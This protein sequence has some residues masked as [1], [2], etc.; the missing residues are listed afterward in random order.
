MNY[1]IF[2][3]IDGTLLTENGTI[4]ISTIDTLTKLKNNG[5]L[6]FICSGR[7]K[8]E[9]PKYILNL[10]F[11][12]IVASAG[13]YVEF[14]SAELFHRPIENEYLLELIYFFQENKTDF[15]LETNEGSYFSKKSYK[16]FVS[17]MNKF[18]FS[19]EEAKNE[20]LAMFSI[21][22]N[23]KKIK[24][25]NKL[26]YF[27]SKY[28]VDE[29]N[30]LLGSNFTFLPGSI[31]WCKN[32]SGEVSEKGINKSTGINILLSHLSKTENDVIAIGDGFNDIEMIAMAK[33]GIA[34]GNSSDQLKEIADYTTDDVNQ[35]GIYNIFRKLLL[36]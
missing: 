14:H 5:H 33:I 24:N 17:L 4:P 36:V 8:G 1:L 26:V 20:Y 29:L 30:G 16:N 10:G 27:N 35:N 18:P 32:N 34:M 28:N 25:V 2:F 3:D 13:A 19:N 23:L 6:L 21:E 9:I 15:I 22:N 12:G 11:D 31:D 7:S